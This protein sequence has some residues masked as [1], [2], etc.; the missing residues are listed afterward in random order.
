[1]LLEKEVLCCYCGT[2]WNSST[3]QGF[4]GCILSSI[5]QGIILPNF[6]CFSSFRCGSCFVGCLFPPPSPSSE[7]LIVHLVTSPFF[8][9]PYV[10]GQAKDILFWGK[11]RSP[12]LFN[13]YWIRQKMR[14]LKI[15]VISLYHEH[16]DWGWKSCREHRTKIK[17]LIHCFR[18]RS[19][20]IFIPWLKKKKAKCW[21][22]RHCSVLMLS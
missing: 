21:D 10:V 14:A 6:Y 13:Y 2:P 4:L 1:M 12:R 15:R 9:S 22:W 7:F 8:L 20:W 16:N 3:G 19:E 18:C 17:Q 5:T 11:K